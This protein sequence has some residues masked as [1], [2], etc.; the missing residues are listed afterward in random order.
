MRDLGVGHAC[1]L[2]EVVLE[3]LWFLWSIDSCEWLHHVWQLGNFLA[4][5]GWV[6]NVYV[7]Y[8]G[9][10]SLCVISFASMSNTS[11]C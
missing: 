1:D 8:R 6:G 9:G 5:K 11:Y 3:S 2:P 10:L 4:N 7:E